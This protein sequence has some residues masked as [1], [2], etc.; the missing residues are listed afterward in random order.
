MLRKSGKY[1]VWHMSELNRVFD[2]SGVFSVSLADC[3]S[4][5]LRASLPW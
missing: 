2:S 3:W 5:F 4:M 1:T